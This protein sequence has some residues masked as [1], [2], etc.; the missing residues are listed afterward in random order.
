[1]TDVHGDLAARV[2]ALEAQV[3]ELYQLLDAVAP[4]LNER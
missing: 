1:M 3:S 4:S 2:A